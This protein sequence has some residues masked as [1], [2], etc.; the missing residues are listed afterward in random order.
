MEV[1]S[2]ARRSRFFAFSSLI[3]L[4]VAFI[5]SAAFFT[6]RDFRASQAVAAYRADNEPDRLLISSIGLD[7]P[8]VS[9]GFESGSRKPAVPDDDIGWFEQNGA[10][11]QPGVV[12]LSGHN[13][14]VFADLHR[15]QIGDRL[16]ISL[17]SD[18]IEGVTYEVYSIAT[19]ARDNLDMREVLAAQDYDYELVLMTCAGELDPSINTYTHRLVLRARRV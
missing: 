18:I 11:D 13:D 6:L 1:F 8:V 14:G 4:F 9:V 19:E 12:F 2:R 7:A 17:V 15:V 16:T 3:T 5:A 10:P